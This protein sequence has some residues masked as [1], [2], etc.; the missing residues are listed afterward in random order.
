MTLSPYHLKYQNRSDVDIALRIR[1]KERELVQV[2]DH[3]RFV[4]TQ[5]PVRIAILGCGDRRFVKVH[6]E[7]FE[8]LL[9]TPVEVITFDVAVEHLAGE[10]SVVQHDCSLPLPTAP[11][12]ITY[13][14]VL[15]KFIPHE[16]QFAVLQNSYAALRPGGVAIH[17]LAPE[18]YETKEERQP[19][20]Y[21]SVPLEK[22]EQELV[23]QK[24]VYQK[25]MIKTGPNLDEDSL[26]L[27]LER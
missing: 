9:S 20:G 22:Y 10:E 14:N 21:F 8:R 4:P 11:Y 17:F 27:V 2:F 18:D 15:L 24:I 26:V 7:I 25:L 3:I 23:A 19:D 1:A 5:S 16:K 13:S 6:K 12:D